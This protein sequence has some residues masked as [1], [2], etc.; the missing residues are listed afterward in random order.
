MKIINVIF[1]FQF[2]SMIGDNKIKLGL[3]VIFNNIYLVKSMLNLF[4]IN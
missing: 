1:V 3:F 4:L 2:F